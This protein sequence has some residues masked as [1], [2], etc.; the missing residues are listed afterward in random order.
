MKLLL[1]GQNGMLGS[2]IFK[3]FSGMKG[4]DLVST[5][6]SGENNTLKYNVLK[7]PII[8]LLEFIKPCYVINCIGLNWSQGKKS[9]T[10][11]Y[12][13]FRVNSI[14]P[15]QLAAAAGYL[16]SHVIQILTDGVYSGTQG[17]YH[18]KSLR[19][20]RSVYGQ[21]KKIGERISK[22]VL[23]LR[24]SII[25]EQTDL[26]QNYLLNWLKYQPRYSSINGY[27]NYY[28][29]GVTS[30]AFAQ[31]VGGIVSEESKIYGIYHLVP[32]NYVS[33]FELLTLLAHKYDR[34]DVQ[35]KRAKLHKSVDRTLA[36]NYPKKNLWFW[37]V[38]GYTSAPSIQRLIKDL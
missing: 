36:T 3:E 22:N 16:D 17:N 30:K 6:R 25:G 38:G 35:I 11:L 20:D 32:T 21:S 34:N 24:C 23:G 1:L 9:I 26:N 27:E 18:E 10:N 5:T 7:D 33:K 29:N 31:I 15:R 28:W 19:N 37:K 2:A 13:T 12:Q 4:V 14:F 8:A